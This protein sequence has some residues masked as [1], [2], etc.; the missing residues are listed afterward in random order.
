MVDVV[1]TQCKCS[2]YVSR[3][4]GPR[5][6]MMIDDYDRMCE[7]RHTSSIYVM[8]T[9]T[10]LFLRYNVSTAAVL[11]QI[12][13]K[14]GIGVGALRRIYGGAQRR[15]VMKKTTVLGA[16]GCIRH[17]LIQFEVSYC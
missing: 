8:L 5:V 17:V 15:G 16:G 9:Y 1:K 4:I 6:M 3:I 14:Q 12:Y 10:L 11:R 7:R 2:I 13:L